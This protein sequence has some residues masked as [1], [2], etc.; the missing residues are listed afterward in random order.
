LEQLPSFQGLLYHP[1]ILLISVAAMAMPNVMHDHGIIHVFPSFSCGPFFALTGSASL[2]KVS[3]VRNRFLKDSREVTQFEKLIRS[4]SCQTGRTPS[5]QSQ[6]A[7]Y[8]ADD[9]LRKKIIF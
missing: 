6:L 1:V 2:R 4:L 9:V 8:G 3:A 7:F 5:Q